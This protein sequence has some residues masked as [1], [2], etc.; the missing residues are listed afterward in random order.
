MSDE[1]VV[2]E[3]VI[4]GSVDHAEER[5]TRPRSIT[6][7]AWSRE[8]RTSPVFVLVIAVIAELQD[9]I[10]GLD[11]VVAGRLPAGR[12]RVGRRWKH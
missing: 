9:R 7:C 8:P 11:A 4:S 6:S 10:D 3:E 5:W 1:D 2:D 12:A